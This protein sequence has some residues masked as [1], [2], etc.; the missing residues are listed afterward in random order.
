[1][2]KTDMNDIMDRMSDEKKNDN[3]KDNVKKWI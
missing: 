3:F 2:S 1:M